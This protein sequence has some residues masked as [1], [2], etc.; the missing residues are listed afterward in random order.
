[1]EATIL[2]LAKRM[3]VLKVGNLIG[4]HDTRLWRV[5]Y[6]YVGEARSNEDFSD[7]FVVGIDET[8]VPLQK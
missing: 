1:M 6:H 4:E 8:S 7:V 5:I 2:E 3:P